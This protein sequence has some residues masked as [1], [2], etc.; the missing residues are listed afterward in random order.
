MVKGDYN[1]VTGN[2]ALENYHPCKDSPT[3]QVIHML[4]EHTDVQNEHTY[5]ENNAAW[6]ADGGQDQHSTEKPP[7]GRFPLAGIKSENY[8]GNN[9]WHGGDGY[10]GSWV[11][12]GETL[13][14]TTDL[15]DML[16]DVDDYDFR[17]KPDSVLVHPN[18]DPFQ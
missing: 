14:P 8:Y 10:D 6:L 11:L 2:M 9:S 15:P 7:W 16:M 3:L 18:T 12:N 5:V 4:R 17:P 13:I 1:N